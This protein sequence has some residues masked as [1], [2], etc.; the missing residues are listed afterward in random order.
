MIRQ[1]ILM[2]AFIGLTLSTSKGGSITTEV[3]HVITDSI[4]SAY[5]TYGND[6]LNNA[7]GTSQELSRIY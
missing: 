2:F 1:L 3:D 6:P 4:T 7:M 5:Y